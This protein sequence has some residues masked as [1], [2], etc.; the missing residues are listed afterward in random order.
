MTSPSATREEDAGPLF[1]DAAIDD[2]LYKRIPTSDQHKHNFPVPQVQDPPST[3]IPIAQE[4]MQISEDAAASSDNH[5]D[6]NSHR[7]YAVPTS[8]DHAP[9]LLDENRSRGCEMR[10]GANDSLCLFCQPF[11]SDVVSRR[12]ACMQALRVDGDV[13]PAVFRSMMARWGDAHLVACAHPKC[14]GLTAA[15][16]HMQLNVDDT[17]D[18]S[19]SIDSC[20]SY[21]EPPSALFYPTGTSE[22]TYN[23]GKLMV[24]I[25]ISPSH[26]PIW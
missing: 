23:S 25:Y 6:T 26:F 3:F 18:N 12:K 19:L 15:C 1:P 10:K 9:P 20:T 21:S 16:D 5:G 7:A 4:R 17:A 8:G 14:F 13:S 22:C 2:G 24:F 11:L